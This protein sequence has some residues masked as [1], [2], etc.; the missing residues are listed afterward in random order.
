MPSWQCKKMRFRIHDWPQSTSAV[1]ISQEQPRDLQKYA[2]LSDI[3]DHRQLLTSFVSLSAGE[4][5]AVEI[6]RH[7]TA[8]TQI[9]CGTFKEM[10]CN[11]GSQ[12]EVGLE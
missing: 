1:W 7:Q 3:T 12:V 9:K 5:P 4:C 2:G 8:N 6:R 11:Y 10:K